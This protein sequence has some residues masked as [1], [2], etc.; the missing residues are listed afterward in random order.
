MQKTL[1]LDQRLDQKPVFF[2]TNNRWNFDFAPFIN[3]NRALKF[4]NQNLLSLH[5][6]EAGLSGSYTY[7][8]A[9][10]FGPTIYQNSGQNLPVNNLG[11]TAYQNS[12]QN[13]FQ[14]YGQ[15]PLSYAGSYQHSQPEA[16][17]YQNSEPIPYPNFGQFN[18]Q[19]FSEHQSMNQL[20]GPSEGI[21]LT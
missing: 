17:S 13:P 21:K 16:I 6:L 15:A 5:I 19:N 2:R 9:N 14:N 8:P 7:P 20:F 4:S 18:P 12:G 10:N 1:F 3:L 11:L